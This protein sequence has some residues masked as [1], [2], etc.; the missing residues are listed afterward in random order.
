MTQKYI[1]LYGQNPNETWVDYR[2]TGYPLLEVPENVTSSFNPSL[3][4]PRRYLYPI[5]ER[6]TNA[7]NYEAAIQRQ[8]GH[9]MDVD[10]W[11]FKP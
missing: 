9:L 11:A 7:E 2:R 8:G 5:G 1:A 6:T 10:M 4:I 3:V